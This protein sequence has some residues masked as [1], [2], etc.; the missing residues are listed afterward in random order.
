VG[1]KTTGEMGEGSEECSAMSLRKR[2]MELNSQSIFACEMYGRFHFGPL[3]IREKPLYSLSRRLGGP[4]TL[5]GC[6]K[7]K[8]R[9][10][11][12]NTTPVTQ[13]SIYNS[14]W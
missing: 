13:I 8:T 14:Q 12:R 10:P 2:H 6:C 9:V 4:Q 5:S 1:Q 7:E 3:Y 11:A